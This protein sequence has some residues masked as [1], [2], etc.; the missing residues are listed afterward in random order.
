[1]TAGTRAAAEEQRWVLKEETSC[2]RAGDRL[3]PA[4]DTVKLKDV[5]IGRH[6][7]RAT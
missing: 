6:D 1:M 5:L 4:S 7:Y 2:N 3:Y